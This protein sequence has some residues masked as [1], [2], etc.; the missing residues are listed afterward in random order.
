MLYI[1]K[2][3]SK[4]YLLNKKLILLTQYILTKDSNKSSLIQQYTKKLSKKDKY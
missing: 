1:L 4:N 2:S 3:Q